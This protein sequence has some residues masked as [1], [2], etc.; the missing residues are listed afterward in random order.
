MK[1]LILFGGTFDPVHLGHITV[2]EHAV[3]K[4]CADEVVFI[5]AKR[6]P[7]KKVFPNATDA[8]RYEM[9]K[10]AV[11]GI[12]NF[13]VS[14]IELTRPDP[15][16][17][18][19]TVREFIKKYEGSVGLYWLIGADAICDLDKWHRIEE[20]VDICSVCIMHRAGFDR[21]DLEPLKRSLSPDRVRKLESNV[22][23]T[24]LIDISS[25]EI[26]SRLALGEDIGNMVN[27]KVLSYILKHAL[28]R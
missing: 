25:T 23:S 6:S 27:K 14:D 9:I 11:D 17:T 21:P 12:E 16:Y 7:H 20:L 3:K 28:Y 19:D 26:R 2:A 1:K 22:I 8:C 13:S 18:I 10:L 24:P 15:S 5:P 4:L